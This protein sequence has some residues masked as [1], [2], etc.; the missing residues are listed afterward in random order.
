M[1]TRKRGQAQRCAGDLLEEDLEN[2]RGEDTS[3]ASASVQF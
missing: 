3:I 2:D 1:F